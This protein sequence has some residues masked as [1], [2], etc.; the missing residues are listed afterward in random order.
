MVFVDRQAVQAGP[1][2]HSAAL[3]PV[4]ALLAERLEGPEQKSAVGLKAADVIVSPRGL[5]ATKLLI[6]VA[7][8]FGMRARRSR[9]SRRSSPA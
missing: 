1:R 5:D 8:G 2:E 7:P 4:A 3:L 6:E 9:C